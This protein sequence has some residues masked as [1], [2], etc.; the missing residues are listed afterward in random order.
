MRLREAYPDAS[1]CVPEHIENLITAYMRR[2]MV[3]GEVAK[4]VALA[5]LMEKKPRPFKLIKG[6]AIVRP[7]KFEYLDNDPLG[8]SP[9]KKKKYALTESSDEDSLERS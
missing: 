4:E 5:K 6:L 2:N 8:A 1:I 3:A 7:N 9:K